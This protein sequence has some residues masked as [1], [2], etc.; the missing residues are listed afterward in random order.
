MDHRVLN[1]R[2]ERAGMFRQSEPRTNAE[3][4]SWIMLGALDTL[5]RFRTRDLALDERL[6]SIRFPMARFAALVLGALDIRS[7]PEESF[8]PDPIVCTPRTFRGKRP[9]PRPEWRAKHEPPARSDLIRIR[10]LFRMFVGIQLVLFGEDVEGIGSID[11][12]VLTTRLDEL[13]D[14]VPLEL[15]LGV[16][17]EAGTLM[18]RALA[19]RSVPELSAFVASYEHFG[20]FC[21]R[22]TMLLKDLSRS[23][24]LDEARRLVASFETWCEQARPILGD[25]PTDGT[26]FPPGRG[27]RLHEED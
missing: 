1:R 2:Q 17:D 11:V 25:T 4:I 10:A 8:G 14:D 27:S 26:Q 5:D 18:R 13:G 15:L 7:L 20:G 24:D 23:A 21:R 9:H 12:G 22:T 16:L 6:S 3:R 19:S